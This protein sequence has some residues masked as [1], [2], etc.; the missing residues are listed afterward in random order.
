MILLD[1][2]VLSELVKREPHARVVAWVQKQPAT[3]LGTTVVTESEI[4]YGIELLSEAENA[5]ACWLRQKHLYRG[6]LR[7]G[8]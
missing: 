5:K 4:F 8:F 3:E 2:N 1:T 6:L 7:T